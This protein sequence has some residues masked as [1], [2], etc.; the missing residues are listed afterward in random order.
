M[1]EQ[2]KQVLRSNDITLLKLSYMTHISPSDL[3]QAMQGKKPF[4]PAWKQ[5]I[6]N[7]LH[8]G[9]I[10]L[11]PVIKQ[12]TAI[13]ISSLELSLE[14]LSEQV[15]NAWWEEKKR[16]GFHG[17]VGCPN[18]SEANMINDNFPCEKCCS[19][20]DYFDKLSLRDQRYTAEIVKGVLDAIKK[21]E[22]MV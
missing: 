12:N 14:S 8:V 2:L 15:H 13:D 3:S 19:H 4:F 16:Q 6:C 17:L 18:M 5:K 9:E 10:N 11:F 20:S 21:M 1:Y 7:A 22:E